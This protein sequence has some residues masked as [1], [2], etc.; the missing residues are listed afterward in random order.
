MNQPLPT[1]DGLSPS[2]KWLPAGAWRTIFDYLKD[3]FP[4]VEADVWLARMARGAVADESGRRIDAQTAYRAGACIFYYREVAAERKIPFVERII[5]RDKH[6]LVA[7]KPHFLPVIPAGEY[8]RETL[9]VRLKAR[10]NLEH[11]APLHRID[12]ETAGVVVFS[13]NPATR[14]IYASLFNDRKVAKIYE[15]L[16]G[17]NPNLEFPLTRRSCLT[18]GAPFFRMRETT[19]EPNSETRVE[20]LERRGNATNLYRLRALTGKKHQIRVHL[21]ALEIPI[22][23]DKFYPHLISADA[24][25][26]SNPL[27]LLAKSVTFPDPI[28][29]RERRF[30]SET[31]L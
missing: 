8:L 19:G 4:A 22:V 18:A 5:Y 11:L 31:K 13:V 15:A 25:D 29:G 10:E 3:E 28:T 30:E 12:R 9:L 17:S 14:S 26:F 1:I 6:I 7:D 24:D 20:L 23:N 16:A 27:K 2:Y 21:A